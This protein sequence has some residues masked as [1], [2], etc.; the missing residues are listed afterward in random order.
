MPLTYQDSYTP[1]RAIVNW[2]QT[3]P[4]KDMRSRFRSVSVTLGSICHMCWKGY[5]LII[6]ERRVWIS[7]LDDLHDK[8]TNRRW[9]TIAYEAHASIRPTFVAAMSSL[10]KFVTCFH[11]QWRMI[12]FSKSWVAMKASR[13]KAQ[14]AESL[15][16]HKWQDYSRCRMMKTCIK[17]YSNEG[18]NW[19]HLSCLQCP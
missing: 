11:C 6:C 4:I 7:V 5:V 1:L 8:M 16:K 14:G 12:A 19:A 15:E 18:A 13:L 10:P 9:L 3:N 17:T 2:D